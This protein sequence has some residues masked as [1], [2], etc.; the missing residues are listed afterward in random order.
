MSRTSYGT[1]SQSVV[2]YGSFHADLAGTYFITYNPR[3]AENGVVSAEN[4]I[5]CHV[6]IR[7]TGSAYICL[8]PAARTTHFGGFLL[9]LPLPICGGQA[10]SDGGFRSL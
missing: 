5:L 4:F 8:D 9:F 7:A 2:E 6:Q 10:S 3:Q 1:V